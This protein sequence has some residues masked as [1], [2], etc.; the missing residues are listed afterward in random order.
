MTRDDVVANTD[1]GGEGYGIPTTGGPGE[2]LLDPVCSAKWAAGFI[3][4]V[5]K[6]HFRKG[7]RVVFLHTGGAVAL[8]GRDSACGFSGNRTGCADGPP[9]RAPAKRGFP[10]S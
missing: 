3:A 6:G 4:L 2:F 7:Q 10:S 1:Y 9:C 5:R 8:F